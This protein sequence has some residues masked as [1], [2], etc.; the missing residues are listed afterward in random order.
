MASYHVSFPASGQPNP[1][2]DEMFSNFNLRGG[3]GS[4]DVNGSRLQGRSRG[5]RD[6]TATASP[7]P[8]GQGSSDFQPGAIVRVK[9]QNFVTYNKAEFFLGPSLNMVIGPNG[10]G[11]SSLVC[12]ICLGLCFPSNVLGRATAYGEYVKHGQDQATIEVE[13]QGEPGEDNYVVGLLITR[14]TNSRDFTINGTK[15]THKEVQRLMSRLRI[16][17]DNLCQFLPQEKVAEFAGL[18]PVELLEKT[19][20]AAAPEEMIAWQN[21][22]KD[23]YKVQAEAQRSADEGGKEIKRLEE[24][25]AALQADVERLREKE[26]YEAAIA[27]LKKLKLVVAYNEAREQFSTEKRRKDEAK[28]RL[29]RLEKQC[30][31]ALKAVNKKQQYAEGIRAAVQTRTA[32]LR[33]AEKD[34]DIA[35]RAI[36]AAD[37]KVKNLAGQL[38][39]EQ[40]AFAAR[41]QELGKIRRRITE[42]EAKYAQNPRAFDPAEWNRRI[43]SHHSPAATT[44][45]VDMLTLSSESKS[46]RFAKRI[47]RLRK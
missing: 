5:R 21:E 38:E 17:I 14:E 11:K 35:V 18:T 22:L 34:A 8:N 1:T 32:R 45:L 44:D 37:S 3:D 47:R 15:V 24:R 19:L 40:G 42:L 43:V 16:Q 2:D 6:S 10:T 13:L 23:H 12:A 29:K 9:L 33:D 36:E 31:P 4:H 30:A 41:R 20:Q 46:T 7:E 28:H 26:Q 27:K 25:Q 39:A